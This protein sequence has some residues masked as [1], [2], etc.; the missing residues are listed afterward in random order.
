M[1]KT[2]HKTAAMVQPNYYDESQ[3]FSRPQ[4]CDDATGSTTC[5][6]KT[7][8][9]KPEQIII[10]IIIITDIYMARIR[11]MQQKRQVNCYSLQLLS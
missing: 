8:L 9:V 1:N 4:I 11:K 10:I 2:A 5:V 7:A 3:S 6:V